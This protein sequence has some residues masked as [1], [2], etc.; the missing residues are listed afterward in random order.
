MENP[1]G[2]GYDSWRMHPVF[3]RAPLKPR[4]VR[5]LFPGFGTALIVT[6]SV[7]VLTA[8]YRLAGSSSSDGGHHGRHH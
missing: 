2:K 4:D 3:V 8:V 1:F 5:L 7:S 6:L